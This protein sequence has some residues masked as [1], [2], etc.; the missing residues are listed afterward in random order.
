MSLNRTAKGIVLVPTLLLGGAFLAAATWLD[1]P[2]AAMALDEV[3]LSFGFI[4]GKIRG[5]SA[6]TERG[7]SF[8]TP[9]PTKSSDPGWDQLQSGGVFVDTDEAEGVVSDLGHSLLTRQVT[10]EEGL[11][12][13]PPD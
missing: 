1:G 9:P 8:D 4:V 2:A 11:E 6:E 3:R 5:Q 13:V 7:A 12:S 10:V